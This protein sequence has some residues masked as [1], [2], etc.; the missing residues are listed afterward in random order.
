MSHE[1]SY[2]IIPSNVIILIHNDKS[3]MFDFFFLEFGSKTLRPQT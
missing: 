2:V 3:K 1:M